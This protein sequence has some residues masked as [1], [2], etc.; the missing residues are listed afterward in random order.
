MGLNR[1]ARL[2]VD[3]TISTLTGTFWH[4]G[5]GHGK[6]G[7]L[8]LDIEPLVVILVKFSDVL[9]P[10]AGHFACDVKF[11]LHNASITK[12]SNNII[13]LLLHKSFGVGPACEKIAD[14]V[15]QEYAEVLCDKEHAP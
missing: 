7:V 13:A 11:R 14:H 12:S 2:P 15:L 10:T 9:V 3:T 1:E 6:V 8:R 4:C 5:D